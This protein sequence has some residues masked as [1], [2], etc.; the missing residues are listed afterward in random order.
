[1]E[2]KVNSLEDRMKEYYEKRTRSFLPR[3]T[4]TIIRIGCN[5]NNLEPKLKRGRLIVKEIY[6]NNDVERTKWFISEPPIFTQD[7]KILCD[8]IPENN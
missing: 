5:W 2:T 4:Y 1:M 6:N 8:L 3:R 7:R